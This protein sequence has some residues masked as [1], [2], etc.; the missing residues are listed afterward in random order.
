MA[1]LATCCC[2]QVWSDVILGPG[3]FVGCFERPGLGV[4]KDAGNKGILFF[5]RAA[6]KVIVRKALSEFEL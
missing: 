3:C 5:E 1:I 6:F 2:Q 4:N